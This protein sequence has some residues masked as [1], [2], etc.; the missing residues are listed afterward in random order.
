V[1]NLVIY[2]RSKMEKDC[3]IGEDL[4][5]M[6]RITNKKQFDDESYAMLLE[7][8]G[9][10]QE[11]AV[12]NHKNKHTHCDVSFAVNKST[13]LRRFIL[14]VALSVHSLF[15]GIMLGLQ[16]DEVKLLHLFLAVLIH[17]LLVAFALGVNIAKLKIGLLNSLKYI[18]IV[19]GSIPTGI[20][21]G[22]VVTTAPGL[23]GVT[24]SAVLQGLTAGI[25]IHITFMEIIPEEMAGGKFC[26]LK[27]TFLFIG[28]ILMA[29]LNF[30]LG[31][32]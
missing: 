14:L 6:S 32:H 12:A 7:D 21:I 30:V 29:I 20:I 27:I 15:E 18:L 19:T 5:H 31:T 9:Q 26:F 28:F 1:E 4:V 2:M 13:G 22:M 17:E 16:T 8:E 10:E 11:V 24:V 3:I 23:A 25:F